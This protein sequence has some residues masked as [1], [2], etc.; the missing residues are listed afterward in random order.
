MKKPGVYEDDV[1]GVYY[2]HLAEFPTKEDFIEALNKEASDM[3][4]VGRIPFDIAKITLAYARYCMAKCE[5]HD[6]DGYWHIE[7]SPGRGRTKVWQ[8]GS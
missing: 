5:W 7:H 6:A 4:D 3:I 1:G 2:G 8:Y